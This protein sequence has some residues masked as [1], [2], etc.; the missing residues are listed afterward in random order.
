MTEEAPGIPAR[1]TIRGTTTCANFLQAMQAL[2]QEEQEE[3]EEQAKQE[4]QAGQAA[5][6]HPSTYLQRLRGLSTD[7]TFFAQAAVREGMPGETL[8]RK[9]R[10]SML[11]LHEERA[12]QAEQTERAL[13]ALEHTERELQAKRAGLQNECERARSQL[14]A[15]L[16][17]APC[18]S[19]SYRAQP[20][21]LPSAHAAYQRGS[22][23]Q[24]HARR[25]Y[26]L[27]RRNSTGISS[28]APAD[29]A[30]QELRIARLEQPL[31]PIRPDDGEAEMVARRSW[32]DSMAAVARYSEACAAYEGQRK[33]F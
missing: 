22:A 17:G 21:Q 16:P 4:E 31:R 9:Q 26:H 3:Q 1:G 30:L 28:V 12:Q 7:S 14:P 29:W 32:R 11:A 19:F 6:R 23:R 5:S 18:I 13:L 8:K 10:A 15:K 27:R 25:G 20:P 24:E 33:H 2:K